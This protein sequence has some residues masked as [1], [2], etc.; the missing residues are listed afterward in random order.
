MTVGTAQGLNLM[1][2]LEISAGTALA[3]R[4]KW[5]ARLIGGSLLVVGN[6][7]GGFFSE[8]DYRFFCILFILQ[9]IGLAV[10]SART[11]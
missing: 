3:A 7:A 8:P 5:R 2:S 4:I 1:A 6:I 11:T 10:S 9:V